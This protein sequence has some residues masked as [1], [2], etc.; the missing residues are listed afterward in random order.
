MKNNILFKGIMPAL[1]TPLNDDSTVRTEA[2]A[3]MM[4][5]MMDQGVAGFYV[6]G[7]T[8]E[9]AVLAEQERMRMAEAAADAVNGTGKK[10]ILHVGAADTQSAIRIARHAGQVGA[11]AISSVYPNFFC[12]YGVEEAL[13]YY[14]ALIDASGLPMLG[15]C[16]SMLQGVDVVQF[17]EK[18]MK[19]D[20]VIGVKYTFPNYYHMHC[21][22]QLNGG[23]INVIN[24]PDETLLCGLSMGADGGI[25]STYNLMADRYVKLYEAVQAN[26]LKKAHEIQVAINKVI[27]VMLHH[28][29]VPSIRVGLEARGFACGHA[30]F[31]GRRYTAEET[32]QILADYRAAGLELE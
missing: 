22:K 31:P 13:D 30:A 15:Y 1:I 18:L 28:G 27:A 9:G 12:H 7:A 6:L 20:G 8:G 3:P 4:K 16:T 5:W 19:I 10:L 32:A 26:D 17:V 24:G 11:D 29:V 14:R 25:G 23:N 2:V 21:I